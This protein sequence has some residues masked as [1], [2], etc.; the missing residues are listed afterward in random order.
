M[1]QVIFFIIYIFCISNS[2][3][4]QNTKGIHFQGIA[5]NE[6]GM[7]IANKQISLRIAILSDTSPMNIEYQEIKSVST[8]TLGLFYTDIGVNETGKVI[9]M[10]IFDTIHWENNEKYLLVELDPNNSLHF[11]PSSFVK[12]HFVPF[13][14]YAEQ[15]KTISTILPINLGGTGVNNLDAL[16][17]KLHLEKINNT[18][19]SSKPISIAT[20]LALN[21]KLKKT[22]TLSLSNRINGKLNSSDTIK[23]SNRINLKLNSA[24]TIGLSNRIQNKLNTSDTISLSNRI[25]V[26]S[27]NF[28]K[29][30]YGIF[31]DTAKQTALAS[32][33]TAIKLSLQQL[34]NKINV[35]NN[36]TGNLTKITVTDPGS[37]F[38]HYNL[39][40]IKSDP[41]NDELIVWFR[42]NNAAIANTN[43]TY[44]VQG[45]GIKNN[46]NNSFLFELNANDY[47][48]LFFSVK[49]SSTI[50][51][52][53]PASTTT[54]SRPATP[55]ASIVLYTVN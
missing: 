19:D 27:N 47:I 11:I 50:L 25:N 38:I 34:S 1:K 36:S 29:N 14:F 6:N 41:G 4:A 17:L 5:R 42:K 12:M 15:A 49:N 30:N 28:P 53:T 37:Y 26:L 48:E 23:L 8:N 54:P 18:P 45:A 35:V 22:D 32:T 44:I 31:Y 39:Q 46:I 10:G 43:N 20:M 13:S 24:D 51:Q 3:V 21:E 52:G 16:L 2:G 9:T 55:S 33:A 7:I 40:F